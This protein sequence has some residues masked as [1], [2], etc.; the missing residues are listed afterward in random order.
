MLGQRCKE[1]SSS[2]EYQKK[3]QHQN[4]S[5]YETLRQTLTWRNRM[6]GYPGKPFPLFQTNTQAL[7]LVLGQRCKEDS[8]SGEY[9]K[10]KQHPSNCKKSWHDWLDHVMIY[11]PG[12]TV[13]R[14]PSPPQINLSV[15]QSVS[16][17]SF[18]YS[19]ENCL[20]PI[21]LLKYSLEIVTWHD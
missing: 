18:N 16:Q 13:R 20:G 9:Q 12:G 17:I 21:N 6:V 3:K 1:V 2:G 19:A 4:N 11:L 14:L 15:S 10:K 7:V 8:S 5:A